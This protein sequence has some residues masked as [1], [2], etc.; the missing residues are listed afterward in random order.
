MTKRELEDRIRTDDRLLALGFS[1]EQ[2]ASLRRISSILHRWTAL[3]C[4]GDVKRDEDTGK[5]YTRR[6]SYVQAND[7]RSIRFVPDR[8]ASALKRLKT[9]MTPFKHRLVAYHQGDP[10]GC[11]LYIVPKKEL[12]GQDIGSV[13]N[14]GI[15]VC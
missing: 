8:E 12:R 14:R 3:E 6:G 9:I 2:V 4:N 5:P 13:Y 7:P 1:R 15:A 10:L 11:A